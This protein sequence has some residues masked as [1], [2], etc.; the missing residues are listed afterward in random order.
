MEKLYKTFTIFN[1]EFKAYLADKWDT[2]CEKNSDY[3]AGQ[4][5]FKRGVIY[6]KDQGSLSE[7]EATFW[8]EVV[9]AVLLSLNY[10]ELSDDEDFVERMGRSF[11]QIRDT[12]IEETLT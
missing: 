9:H 6:V 7:V 3:Y 5:M 12:I 11:A 1:R 4:C 8:H 10:D 2:E